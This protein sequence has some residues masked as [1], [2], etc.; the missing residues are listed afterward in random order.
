MK[1]F[2][3]DIDNIR[4]GDYI[5]GKYKIT[6]VV[7]TEKIPFSYFLSDDEDEIK[8]T[9][10]Y[11]IENKM[12]GNEL[13]G[14][15]PESLLANLCKINF[16]TR[17]VDIA[18]FVHYKDNEYSVEIWFDELYKDEFDFLCK[19]YNTCLLGR[20]YLTREHGDV[21]AINMAIFKPYAQYDDVRAV[22]AKKLKEI[23]E[24]V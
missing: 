4:L 22:F 23:A 14:V 3:N 11:K 24:G 18:D 1:Q 13:P 7:V 21:C 15:I 16:V 8:S 12:D 5:F 2:I 17:E 10:F 6:D 19:D 9:T 20:I